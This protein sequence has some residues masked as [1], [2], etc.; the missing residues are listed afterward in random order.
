MPTSFT[1]TAHPP[2]TKLWGILVCRGGPKEVTECFVFPP[3]LFG[4]LLHALFSTAKWQLPFAINRRLCVI[5]TFLVKRLYA[6][7]EAAI[8]ALVR[9]ASLWRVTQWRAIL[10]HQHCLLVATFRSPALCLHIAGRTPDLPASTARYPGPPAGPLAALDVPLNVVPPPPQPHP[11]I[12][13]F[14]TH[15]VCRTESFFEAGFADRPSLPLL[16]VR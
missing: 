11:T 10:T 7:H 9:A 4:R 3:L 12:P 5:R 16:M 6:P 1:A 13:A 8:P 2:P 15:C 14:S